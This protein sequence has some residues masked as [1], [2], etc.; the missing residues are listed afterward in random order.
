[1]Q[2]ELQEDAGR[3]E[4]KAEHTLGSEPVRVDLLIIKKTDDRGR[5]DQ[6]AFGKLR[7]T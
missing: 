6:Q 5:R 2:I 1:M 3:L 4:F 7:G